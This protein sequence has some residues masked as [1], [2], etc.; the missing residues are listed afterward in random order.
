MCDGS[1]PPPHVGRA[2]NCSLGRFWDDALFFLSLFS[3][4]SVFLEGIL[5]DVLVL[6]K[7]RGCGGMFCSIIFIGSG[8]YSIWLNGACA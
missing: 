7:G 5:Q 2:S 3:S 1:M 8:V 4:G 6:H